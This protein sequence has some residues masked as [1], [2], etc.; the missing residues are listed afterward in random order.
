MEN[1]SNNRVVWIDVA[2]IAACILIVAG[3]LLRGLSS[4]GILTCAV[5]D[6]TVRVLYFFHVQVF[7]F[8][9]G[10]LYRRNTAPGLVS[11]GKNILKK[12]VDL[13][14]PYVCFTVIS[15]FLKVIFESDVNRAVRRV[16]RHYLPRIGIDAV[17]HLV[18]LHRHL[19]PLLVI[20]MEVSVGEQCNQAHEETCRH[21]GVGV[22]PIGGQHMTKPQ[23][24]HQHEGEEEV[25]QYHQPRHQQMVAR[26]PQY[27]LH[28]HKNYIT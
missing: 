11:W 25:E 9:S 20:I 26:R 13:G 8:C 18:G 22:N 6:S 16:N 23:E 17:E 28:Q 14:V 15:Y 19:Y 7:F 1:R 12:L 4:S 24:V 5:W 10:F 21:P 27:G 3:H 2:K